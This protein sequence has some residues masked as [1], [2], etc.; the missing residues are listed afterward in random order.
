MFGGKLRFT[1]SGIWAN[2]RSRGGGRGVG[3]ASGRRRVPKDLR[4]A[5]RGQGRPGLSL[6]SPNTNLEALSQACSRAPPPP[7]GLTGSHSPPHPNGH[8]RRC[9]EE[10]TRVE[11]PA[12]RLRMRTRCQPACPGLNLGSGSHSAAWREGGLTSRMGVRLKGEHAYEV[13]RQ[14]PHTPCP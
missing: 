12:W 1:L 4:L 14:S 6:L 8:R 13:G 5:G 9:L 11:A 3:D 7:A 2:H 10:I